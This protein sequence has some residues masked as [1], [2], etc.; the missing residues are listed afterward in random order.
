[1]NG[2]VYASAYLGIALVTYVVGSWITY[3][4][5]P[6]VDS[7]LLVRLSPLVGG[8]RRG[9]RQDRRRPPRSPGR[10]LERPLHESVWAAHPLLQTLRPP[11]R[12]HLRAPWTPPASLGADGAFL[13]LTVLL[14]LFFA[15]YTL[16]VAPYLAL[17]P[18]LAQSAKERIAW[19]GWQGLF[20][21]VGIAVGGLGA[22]LLIESMG[23]AAMGV[24]L[25]IISLASFL[26]PAWTSGNEGPSRKRPRFLY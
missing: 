11:A 18:E 22:G 21:I 14:S 1:M 8:S 3:F 13:Y 6:P 20:N 26:L 24:I 4:Y 23:F 25:A 12:T 7:G 2:I 16:Y 19:S 5:A 15:F 10:G 17:L 9:S